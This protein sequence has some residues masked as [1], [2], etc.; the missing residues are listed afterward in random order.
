[1]RRPALCAIYVCTYDYMCYLS[2]ESVFYGFE[3]FEHRLHL[4]VCDY[5]N[6]VLSYSTELGILENEECYST[7]YDKNKT[8]VCMSNAFIYTHSK[9]PQTNC[10][11]HAFCWRAVVVICR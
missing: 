4:T 6:S 10:F 5:R 9:P 8:P 2:V 1:M 11:R 7:I 3:A